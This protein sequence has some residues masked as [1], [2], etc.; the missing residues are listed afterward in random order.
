MQNKSR[1][2]FESKHFLTVVLTVVLFSVG[3][4][5]VTTFFQDVLQSPLFFDT[6]FMIAALFLFGP[7]A[8]FIEYLLF[9]TLVCIKLQVLYGKTDYTFLYVLSALTIILVAWAFIYKKEN[10]TKGVNITFLYLF[11]A[12][13]FAGLA[14]AIVSGCINYFVANLFQKD[15]NF[16][17]I[18]FAFNG[19]YL[20]F[21]T[22][23]II[24]RIPV[25]ILDRVITTFAG[26]GISKLYRKV[27]KG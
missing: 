3:D 7:V 13:V 21:L 10:L 4:L 6:I 17:K 24:G 16:N 8:S 22:S 11:T 25:T 27:L 23:A 9:I 2:Q 12:S 5:C 20:D 14:C 1:T 18:I 15:W 26:F 19:E